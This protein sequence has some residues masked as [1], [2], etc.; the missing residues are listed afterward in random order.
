M[1]GCYLHGKGTLLM[2]ENCKSKDADT[3]QCQDKSV[4]AKGNG[5]L[6]GKDHIKRSPS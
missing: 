6:T 2:M 3:R 1:H 4:Q 5:D